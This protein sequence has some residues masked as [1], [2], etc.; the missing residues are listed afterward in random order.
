[1]DFDFSRFSRQGN[2]KAGNRKP[3][4]VQYQ[5]CVMD[6]INFIFIKD[7]NMSLTDSIISGAI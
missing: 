5:V 3:K 4:Y 7:H 1:M 2:N 6:A